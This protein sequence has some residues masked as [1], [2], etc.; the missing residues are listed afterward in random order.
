MTAGPAASSRRRRP[1]GDPYAVLEHPGELVRVRAFLM[2]VPYLATIYVSLREP[3]AEPPPDS[4][5]SKVVIR[6]L[7]SFSIAFL[8]RFATRPTAKRRRPRPAGPW[9]AGPPR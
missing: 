9:R 7:R 1:L 4:Y 6:T 2:A 8:M 3:L 5:T